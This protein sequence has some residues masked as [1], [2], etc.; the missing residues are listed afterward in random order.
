METPSFKIYKGLQRPLIFKI[1]KGKFIYWA[2]GSIVTGVIAG[3]AASIMIS[4][5]AGA[6]VMVMVAVPLL[7][8]TIHKQKSGLYAK[9]RESCIYMIPA[10]YKPSK[11]RK[12]LS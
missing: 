7:F 8:F 4:S 10:R 11:Q 6:I 9:T 3:G 2:L 5:I 12:Q 1:F